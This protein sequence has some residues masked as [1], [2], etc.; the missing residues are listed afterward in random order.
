MKTYLDA[1]NHFS[2]CRFS[3]CIPPKVGGIEFHVLELSRLQGRLGCHVD[4]FYQYGGPVPLEGVNFY[5]ISGKIFSKIGYNL[6]S[7]AFIGSILLKITISKLFKRTRY[8]II[9]AHGGGIEAFGAYFIGKLFRAISIQTLHGG[10]DKRKISRMIAKF[11]LSKPKHIIAVSEAIRQ[12]LVSL[13]LPEKKI[14]V[15]SSGIN[16][17]VINALD[18]NIQKQFKQEFDLDSYKH[19]VV[20]VGSLDE[21]KGFRYL[22]DAVPLVLKSEPYSLF[23]V[24]GSG[25]QREFLEEKANGIPNIIFAG[26]RTRE[27]IYQ[28]LQ[29]ANLFVLPSITLVGKEEGTPTVLL[30]AMAAGLPIVSTDSGG[31]KYLLEDGVNALLVRQRDATALADAIIKLLRDEDL[32]KNISIRNKEI[33]KKRDWNIVNQKVLHLYN[34]LLK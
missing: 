24:I 15:L 2:I 9:H 13:G 25:P 29:L 21:V 34:K 10:L 31:I 8:D 17:D 27:E 4:L 6:H 12:E 28:I 26:Q 33:A 30:E 18:T 5:R 23:V 14:T 7:V 19:F 32:R 1:F 11:C 3:K 20:S 22:V 16:F